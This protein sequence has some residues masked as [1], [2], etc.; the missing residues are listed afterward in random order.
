MNVLEMSKMFSVMSLTNHSHIEFDYENENF[1]ALSSVPQ[2]VTEL[3]TGSL[4][5]NFYLFLL[6][7]LQHSGIMFGE[8]CVCKLILSTY[9][10]RIGAIH[11]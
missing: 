7:R 2:F 5:C 10:V 11:T 4:M 1:D 8:F 3:V 9:A 6:A